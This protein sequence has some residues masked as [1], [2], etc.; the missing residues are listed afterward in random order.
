MGKFRF[1]NKAVLDLS[2][3]WNYTY[4]N[5]SENQADKYYRMLIETCQ[6]LADNPK[7]GSSYPLIM[8][9]LWGYRSGHHIIFYRKVKDDEIEIIRILHE[10]MDLKNRLK[11]K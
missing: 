7:I 4:T 3:I 6:G 10:R 9:D 1:S 8:A 11:Q 2:A 5:W